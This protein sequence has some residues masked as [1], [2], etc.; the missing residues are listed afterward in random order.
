M[1]CFISTDRFVLSF[2]I[3]LLQILDHKHQ[4]MC[5]SGFLSLSTLQDPVIDPYISARRPRRQA[6]TH[7]GTGTGGV[8]GSQD[9]EPFPVAL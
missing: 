6:G 1:Q 4:K 9:S 3:L 2:L 8:G 7:G 5:L